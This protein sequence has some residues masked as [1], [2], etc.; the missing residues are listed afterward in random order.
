[1]IMRSTHDR[2]HRSNGRHYA[3]SAKTV[4]AAKY[5]T[6]F[7]QE[8]TKL[9]PFVQE[10]YDNPYKFQCTVCMRQVACDHQGKR[11]IERHMEKAM[12]QA[13][14]KQ[15]KSQKNPGFHLESSPISEQVC[16]I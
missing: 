15:M 11:D 6:K 2:R 13:N 7:H 16:W 9:Y 3:A 12:H 1:M 10:V 5:R 14:L 8:W 4:G